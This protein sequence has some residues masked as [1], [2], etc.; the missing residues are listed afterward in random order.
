[1]LLTRKSAGETTSHGLLTRSFARRSGAA[2]NPTIDRRTF[3]KRAGLGAGVGAF[4]S[5][6]GFSMI[7]EAQ[8]Q[9]ARGADKIEDR[10]SVV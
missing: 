2:L 5:Q 3:M 7:E 1:M 6:L 10:K 4:A 9:E 8:A